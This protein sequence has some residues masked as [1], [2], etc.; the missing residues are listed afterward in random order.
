MAN[1]ERTDLEWTSQAGN[2][3]QVHKGVLVK[4]PSQDFFEFITT[5]VGQLN[6]GDFALE[7]PERYFYLG[8]D[9]IRAMALDEEIGFV[10]FRNRDEKGMSMLVYA[11]NSPLEYWAARSGTLE[12]G[13]AYQQAFRMFGL[14][15]ED[16]P[17]FMT[18]HVRV[19]EDERWCVSDIFDGNGWGYKKYKDTLRSLECPVMP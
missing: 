1:I 8:T 18:G 13:K 6:G 3:K 2:E 12:S 4:H 5:I 19:G 15:V 10:V 7:F 16:D 9:S 11:S 17:D 14:D